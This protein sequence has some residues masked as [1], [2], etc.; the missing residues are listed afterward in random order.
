VLIGIVA[1][2]QWQLDSQV[3]ECL[4]YIVKAK[5]NSSEALK[6]F[7]NFIANFWSKKAVHQDFNDYELPEE[8]KDELNDFNNPYS[9]HS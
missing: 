9:Y 4:K 5:K 2:R 7:S 3:E 8:L 6:K 1:S